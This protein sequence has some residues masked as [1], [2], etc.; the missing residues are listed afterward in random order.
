[1]KPSVIIIAL[2]LLFATSCYQNKEKSEP[3]ETATELK[4]ELKISG[5]YALGPL[6][7]DWADEFM[8]IHP[9]LVIT[10]QEEGSGAGI[11]NLL[12]GSTDLAMISEALTPEQENSGLWRIAVSREGIVAIVNSKNPVLDELLKQGISWEE[13]GLLFAGNGEL[14]WGSVVGS[15]EKSPVRVYT[16]SDQSGAAGIWAAYLGLKK[17]EMKGTP[18]Q[19]DTG[20]IAGILKDPFGLSFCNAHYAFNLNTDSPVDGLKVLP[21]DY[22]N[23]GMLDAREQ[24]FEN[25]SKLH[26]AAYLGTYPSH[27]CRELLL[28]S[29]EKPTD[30]N[31][32][33]FITWILTDGQKMAVESGYCEIRHCE[34]ER[35]LEEL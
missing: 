2:F 4:G 19:G 6:M 31:I 24:I 35:V 27:L 11:S 23:N 1:M 8:K 12:S 30:P 25:L 14:S 29:T 3:V 26:R 15:D 10:V 17:D 32:V 33:E 5:A 7:N 21:I 9:D 22:N 34:R 13:L 20:I 16:R 28:V 18:L